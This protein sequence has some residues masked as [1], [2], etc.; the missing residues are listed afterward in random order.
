MHLN[1]KLSMLLLCLATLIQGCS[2]LPSQDKRM[3]STAITDTADTPLGKAIAPLAAAHPGLSGI[4]PLQDPYD[5]FAARVLLARA[6]QRALDVQY[7][8]WR[9]DLTGTLLFEALHEAADRGVRVRLLLDDNNTNGLDETL[10]MLD[11][12]P[13]I[14]VRLF[15][16]FA[17]R[18]PRFIGYITDFS[19]AN[20]R[21]HNK[22]FTA[23]NQATIIGGRNIGDEY[24]GATDGMLFAD[25]DVLG[26]GPVVD[27]VSQ[28]FDRYWNSQSSYPVS[29]LLPPVPASRLAGLA[30]EA[31]VIERNP[32]AAEYIRAIRDADF[33][34]QLEQ[35]TL[36]MEWATARMVS[37]DPAKGLGL[38]PHE[39]M[40]PDQLQ[41]IIGDPRTDVE[42]I[43]PYFVPTASGVAAFEKLAEGGVKVMILTNS[44]EATDVSAVHAGYA[45]RRKPLLEAG[46]KL[47][48][49]R[50][51]SLNAEKQKRAGILG[52][53]GSSLHAKTFAVDRSRIFVGSFNFDPR[54][55]NLNTEMGFVIDSPALASQIE[56][57]FTSTIP[58]NAYEVR[59]SDTG[60]LYWIARIDGKEIRYD[61]EP[62]T[63]A[64]LRAWV[65]FVSVLPIEWLL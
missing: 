36:A 15:N 13:N 44:L 31:S 52:S 39:A 62:G 14:E 41:E 8:I 48:E 32:A 38:A 17:I 58:A 25:L 22:S 34:R 40:L 7:Y 63:S 28:D 65:G 30:A 33:I 55:A 59:L 1:A 64:W 47:Y 57:A 46:I 50:R 21:M 3:A 61:T 23:D 53:S 26:V 42:L 27:A 19:R 45:K 60:K 43:S 49:L 6:A 4:H 51:L 11:A 9:D 16:P 54:S 29:E 56:E 20:R 37:D 10:A 24:F 5:A 2:G 12:H 18:N 35:N